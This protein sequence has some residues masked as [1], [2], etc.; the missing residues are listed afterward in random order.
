MIGARALPPS[1]LA[2]TTAAAAAASGAGGA[3][4]EATSRIGG[5][6]GGPGLRL[7]DGEAAWVARLNDWGSTMEAS[8]T[9]MSVANAMLLGLQ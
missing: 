2:M 5:G 6:V 3:G 8:L 4:A 9:M 1:F 7:G